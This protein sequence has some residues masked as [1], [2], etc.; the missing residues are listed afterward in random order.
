[1]CRT[2]NR[3]FNAK[4]QGAKEGRYQTGFHGRKKE[5]THTKKGEGIET[6]K[7]GGQQAHDLEA[8]ARSFQ[9]EL[10]AGF[11]VFFGPTGELTHGH[12]VKRFFNHGGRRGGPP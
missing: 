8:V 3:D 1:L 11:S 2:K 6:V 7:Y 4:T 5:Q 9:H 12:F 10:I